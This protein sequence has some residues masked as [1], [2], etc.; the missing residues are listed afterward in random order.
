MNLQLLKDTSAGGQVFALTLLTFGFGI[1]FLFIG[2]I[3]SAGFV[4]GD[5]LIRLE[6]MDKMQHK[7]DLNLMKYF[8]IVTQISFFVIPALIFGYFINKNIAHFFKLDKLP[9][10][11]STGLALLVLFL[12]M[13]FIDWLIYENNLIKLPEAFA[14]MEQWMRDAEE[15][16][17]ILTNHFLEMNS[18]KDYLVNILMIGVLAAIGEELLLRGAMQ[19][20][21]IKIFKNAHIGIWIAALIFSFMHFQFYGFFARLFLGALLGYF[22]YYTNNLWI[23]II[24]HF[25]NN[26]AAVTYVYITKTPLYTEGTSQMVTEPV[27]TLYAFLSLSMVILGVFIIR[28]YSQKN[29]SQL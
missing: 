17:A 21:L 29:N 26:S 2:I 15:Q 1:L 27:E 22:F 11:Y 16:A 10:W 19:P 5:V 18:F 23:P 24:A 4:D 14:S 13:P 6:L 25:I 28:Y 20:L 7:G 3:I 12:A 8:Q 9:K